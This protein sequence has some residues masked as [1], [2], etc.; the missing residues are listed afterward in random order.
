M[1]S[2]HQW[3]ISRIQTEIKIY[4]HRDR[5]YQRKKTLK[6]LLFSKTIIIKILQKQLV[7]CC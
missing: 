7:R 3:N 2:L 1:L 4:H 5:V 6:V